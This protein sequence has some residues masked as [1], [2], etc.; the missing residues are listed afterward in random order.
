MSPTTFVIWKWRQQGCRSEY[1]SEYVNIWCS[2]LRRSFPYKH[3]II[4]V[5]DDPVGIVECETY[6]LWRDHDQIVNPN[7]S[8]LPSCYRRLK[9]FSEAQTR[10]MGIDKNERVVSI[11][12]DM[13]FLGDVTHIF[14]IETLAFIGWKRPGISGQ[15]NSYNGSLFMFRTGTMDKIWDE[16]DPL[17][18]PMTARRA[19]Y[20]GS[21]QGWMSYILRGSMPGWGKVDGIYSFSSDISA[22]PFPINAKLISFNGNSK[23]WH[24]LVQA[25]HPWVVRYW[26]M[27]NV[28]PGKDFISRARPRQRRLVR[29]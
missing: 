13:V 18:S 14:N 16:F 5:T 24:A 17:T 4:C 28:L 12:L 22:K 11:D 26:R 10:A 19:K 3:R 29:R 23:P 20:Y 21:D 6:P 9:I 27:G 7:G 8:H 1:R 2:M 15:P 25:Q